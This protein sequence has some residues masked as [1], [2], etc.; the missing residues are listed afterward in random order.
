MSEERS[1]HVF[2]SYVREDSDRVDFLCDVLRASD[3]PYW[4]D[5]KDIAPG[6][7]WKAKIR[8]AI[9]NGSLI[10]LA[11]FSDR[12]DAKKKST[13][14]E[15]LLLAA[16]EFRKITPGTTWLIPV[17]FS[18]VELPEIDLTPTLTLSGLQYIDLFGPQYAAQAGALVSTIG[19]VMGSARPDAQTTLVAAGEATGAER[20]AKL[21]RLTKEMLPDPARRIALDDLIAQEVSEI[22]GSLNDSNKFPHDKLEGSNEEQ[23]ALLVDTAEK[24]WAAV[25]PF[26]NSLYVAARWATVEQLDPWIRGIK[27]LASHAMKQANGYEVLS[28][29]R[30]TPLL[31]SVIVAATASSANGRWDNLKALLADQTVK[32]FFG[33]GETLDLIGLTSF[34]QPL[35]A[36]PVAASA[37][38]RRAQEKE[39]TEDAIKYFT[40]KRGGTRHTPMA[41]WL[42]ETIRPIFSDQYPDEGGYYDEFERAIILLGVI[43][44]DLAA[45]RYADNP[46][47]T[48]L[49]RSQWFGRSTWSYSARLNSPVKEIADEL[50]VQQESCGP[51]RAGL[52][53]SSVERA[54]TAMD[55]YSDEYDHLVRN[56]F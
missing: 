47:H 17:R 54:R 24:Y 6:D 53:G 28:D 16:E 26:C 9:Q 11:C 36:S 4:R 42:F 39:S 10:F 43:E 35:K 2:I 34:Y 46:N 19:R 14:N 27:A 41:D 31:I 37:L 40:D 45:V 20:A 30:H 51:L 50:K 33:R 52:F 15:E 23:L 22:L 44:R 7:N 5:R 56:R 29:L 8:D 49:V 48:W 13:M 1:Q 12:S 25:E 55:G 18:D 3:I 32:N 38:A 21:K